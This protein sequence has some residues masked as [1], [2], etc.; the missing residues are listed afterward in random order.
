MQP[1]ES[2]GMCPIPQVNGLTCHMITVEVL[3]SLHDVRGWQP[4]E[5]L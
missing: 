4:N 1:S 2:V 3:H 5:H